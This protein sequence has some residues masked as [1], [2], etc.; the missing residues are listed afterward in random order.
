LET[1]VV[2]D[3]TAVDDALAD[4]IESVYDDLFAMDQAT[5][6]SVS[7]ELDHRGTATGIPVH[8]E[9]G[10]TVIA[11]LPSELLCRLLT[12]ISPEELRILVDTVAR[13]VE[14]AA[15]QDP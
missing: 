7:A 11:D 10:R 12:A 14:M 15:R 6:S 9:N 13:A 8:L 2:I 5:Y 4:R 3:D 1:L